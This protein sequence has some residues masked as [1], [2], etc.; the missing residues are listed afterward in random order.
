MPYTDRQ[1]RAFF[2][3]VGRQDLADDP[4]FTM[5]ETRTRNIDLLYGELGAILKTRT[6]SEW[7][8]FAEMADIPAAPI[9]SMTEVLDDPHLN[10]VSYFAETRDA[11]MGYLRHPGVPISFDGDRPSIRRA[12]R[13]GE[14]SEEIFAELGLSA[15]MVEQLM[16][17]STPAKAVEANQ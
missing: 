10:D 4:R 7:L 12:P 15:V 16:A 6:V 3:H 14:H 17:R 11:E 1:W 5:M 2:T 9:C 8:A 13:L